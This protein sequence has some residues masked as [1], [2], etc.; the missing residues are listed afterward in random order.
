MLSS[1]LSCLLLL[2]TGTAFIRPLSPLHHPPSATALNVQSFSFTVA[3]GLSAATR[4]SGE[5]AGMDGMTGV[6][7]QLRSFVR[8]LDH[9]CLPCTLLSLSSPVS[10]DTHNRNYSTVHRGHRNRLRFD[11]FGVLDRCGHRATR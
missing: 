9:A 2:P 10:T 4:L 3:D 11:R 6:L 1:R 5:T 8:V 7:E